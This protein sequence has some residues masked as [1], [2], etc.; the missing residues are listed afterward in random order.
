MGIGSLVS[1]AAEFTGNSHQ[2]GVNGSLYILEAL[3]WSDKRS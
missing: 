1:K 2:S 3:L